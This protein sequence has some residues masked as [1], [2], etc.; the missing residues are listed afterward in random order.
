MKLHRVALTLL[1]CFV[2]LASG[3]QAEAPPIAEPP[4]D[5]NQARQ[6]QRQWADRIG[7]EVFHTNSIGMKLAPISAGTFVMGSPIDERERDDEELPHEVT[8]SKS[9]Y[10]AM[11]PIDPCPPTSKNPNV[12]ESDPSGAIAKPRTVASRP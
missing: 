10:A 11:S 1:A 4:F 8:I 7:K 5:A 6:L 3:L 9:F 2:R 12:G